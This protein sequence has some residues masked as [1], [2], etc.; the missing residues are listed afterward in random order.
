M[1]IAQLAQRYEAH[2]FRVLNEYRYLDPIRPSELLDDRSDKWI[3]QGNVS[4]KNEFFKMSA[5]SFPIP[6]SHPIGHWMTKEW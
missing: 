6:S 3:H 1:I 2:L 4:K 5:L